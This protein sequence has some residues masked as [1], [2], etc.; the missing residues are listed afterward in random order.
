MVLQGI[1]PSLALWNTSHSAGVFLMSLA[2]PLKSL[3]FPVVPGS[4]KIRTS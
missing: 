4:A 1:R 3:V 2:L